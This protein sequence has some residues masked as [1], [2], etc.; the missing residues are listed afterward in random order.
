MEKERKARH[1]EAQPLRD[2]LKSNLV[3]FG[4]WV[5]MSKGKIFSIPLHLPFFIGAER[6]ELSRETL[7]HFGTTE[8]TSATTR[9]RLI[10]ALSSETRHGELSP[11]AF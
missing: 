11:V 10:S 1:L 3:A 8:P 5:M 6:S 4:I 7:N 2:V 9:L